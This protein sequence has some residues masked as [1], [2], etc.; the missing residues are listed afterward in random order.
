[1]KV[2][3]LI[4][5]RMKSTRLPKKLTLKINDREIIAL[6]IERLKQSSI[7]D[8]IIVATSNNPQD[9]ILCKIAKREKI[10]CFKGGE[11]DVL[12][13]LFF[14]AENYELDYILN[15]TA[16]C[17]LVSFDFLGKVVD[18]YKKRSSDLITNLGLPHGFYFYGIKIRALKKILEIKNETDTEVWGP[19]FTDNGLFKVFDMKIPDKLHRKY[20]LTL[21]YPKDF[22]FFKAVYEG[23]GKEAYK[24]S[25]YEIIQFLDKHPEIVNINLN[26]EEMYKKRL[27]SQK[28]L[29]L[30]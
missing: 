2:G 13:R 15:I 7:L 28:K 6:M 1:M 9:E 5:A 17:P 19:Y 18:E 27:D 10:N 29:G 25:T 8:E 30:K 24:K 20:R 11:D 26:L 12:E 16:D 3:F 22:E 21:D 14:A 23:L 4:T